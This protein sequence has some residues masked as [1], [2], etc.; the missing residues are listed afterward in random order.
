[1]AG[2]T[3]GGSHEPAVGDGRGGRGGCLAGAGGGLWRLRRQH[4]RRQSSLREAPVRGHAR[5]I[6]GAR[7]RRAGG[8]R[9]AAGELRRVLLAGAADARQGLEAGSAVP[10]LLDVLAGHVAHGREVAGV[11]EADQGP[12]VAQHT[13]EDLD[14]PGMVEYAEV[15]NGLQV[16]RL[17][18]P[19]PLGPEDLSYLAKRVSKRLLDGM[20]AADR[21]VPETRS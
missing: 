17:V 21:L 18:L 7:L 8:S 19:L 12:S 11:A 4:G 20:V 6:R 16:G 13:T 10:G 5:V 2:T 14:R 9:P 1:M 3:R 15:E